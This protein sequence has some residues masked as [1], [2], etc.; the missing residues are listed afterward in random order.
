MNC[1]AK[2]I[3]VNNHRDTIEYANTPNY[4]LK[5]VSIKHV[6]FKIPISYGILFH[7]SA[8][9]KLTALHWDDSNENEI[10]FKFENNYMLAKF[11]YPSKNNT[12]ENNRCNEG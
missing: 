9:E 4:H 11:K 7:E 6:I 8:I 5:N 10:E 12:R 3:T 1:Q 2:I